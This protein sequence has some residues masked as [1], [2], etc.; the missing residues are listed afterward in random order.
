MKQDIRVAIT[1]GLIELH[2]YPTCCKA[3]RQRLAEV[4]QEIDNRVNSKIFLA[5]LK[6]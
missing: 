1:T 3:E 6:S 4:N 2:P 5:K